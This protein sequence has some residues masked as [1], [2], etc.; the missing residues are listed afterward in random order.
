MRRLLDPRITFPVIVLLLGLLIAGGVAYAMKDGGSTTELVVE[1][2]STVDDPN[3]KLRQ[4]VHLHADFALFI[5][6]EQFDFNQP[7]FVADESGGADHHPYLHIHP[8]RFTV[9]HVHLSGSTWGEFFASL[10]FELED[11]TIVGV[12]AA[13]TC[14]GMPDGTRYCSNETERLRF[15]RNGV[16]VDGIAL[17]DISDVERVLITYGSESDEEIQ[18]QI[19]AVT[20][21]AC[22]PSGLCREREVPGE[23]ENC[24]GAGSCTG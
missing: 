19:A 9:V 12:E 11:P 17:S 18:E 2:C 21:E 4:P 8:E 20:D 16:E 10:G 15:F 3:C 1:S 14:L 22:I 5:R 23:V 7:E 24:A 6:G 13:D